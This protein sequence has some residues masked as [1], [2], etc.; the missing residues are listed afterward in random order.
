VR[1]QQIQ[2]LTHLKKHRDTVR[3]QKLLHH[4]QEEAHHGTVL[5][6][7]I[8]ACVEADATVGEISE[9]LRSVFGLYQGRQ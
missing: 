5:M 1:S 9:A 4:L 3:V 8:I 7:H 2:R 6:P